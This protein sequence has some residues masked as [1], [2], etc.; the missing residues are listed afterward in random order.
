M[1]WKKHFWVHK[2]LFG[3]RFF[4][5][6]S[7]SYLF[8]I[9]RTFFHHK[10]PL[11]K[12]KDSSD[13]KGSSWNHLDEKGSSMASWSTFIFK[14]V[15]VGFNTHCLLVQVLNFKKMVSYFKEE[16]SYRM[17]WVWVNEDRIL[18]LGKQSLSF[19]RDKYRII[20]AKCVQQLL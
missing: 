2:E 18:F 4:K 20:V 11:V 9:W 5:E 10:E 19:V 12:Q 6:S 1:P 3:Q 17:M 15:S 7:L 14:S 13:V 8:I 16:K